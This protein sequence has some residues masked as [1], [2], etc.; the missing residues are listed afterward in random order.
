MEKSFLFCW[1]YEHV[2]GEE[3]EECVEEGIG[4]SLEEKNGNKRC[5]KNEKIS[6]SMYQVVIVKL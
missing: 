2:D 5:V 3:E 1:Q 4:D 6:S